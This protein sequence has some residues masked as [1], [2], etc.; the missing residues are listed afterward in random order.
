[1]PEARARSGLLARPKHSAA[2]QIGGETR[3]ITIATRP[4]WVYPALGKKEKGAT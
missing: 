2:W 3:A 4:S 1:M